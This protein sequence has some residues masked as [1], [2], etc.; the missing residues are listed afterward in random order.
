MTSNF[1]GLWRN[2]LFL[3]VLVAF[4]IISIWWL[5]IQPL[6]SGTLIEQKHLWSSSYVF[7]SF[8]GGLFGILI[9]RKWGGYRSA[10]GRSILA[11]SLGLFLQT[12]GQLVYN[13]YTLV[14][15]VEAP[16]PSLGDLGY[17][18]SIFAYLYGAILLAKTAGVKISLKSYH[19]QLIAVLFPLLMLSAS[20]AVFLNSYEFDW[21]QP[22]KVF[23]DFGYPLGQACYV[24]VAILT[25]LLC[26][27]TLGGKMRSPVL[28]ILFALVVQY[29]C[30]SCF[31]FEA[32]QGLWYAAGPGDYFYVLSYFLMSVSLIQLG[33]MY[34]HI[35]KS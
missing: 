20:Y 3:I 18:G 16:Y 12:F 29:F 5:T 32:N 28:W 35:R 26:G 14:A 17:F 19:S 31:L 15:H 13:Y 6:S 27:N 10:V 30:D 34:E 2:Y 7:L 1:Q 23:L 24:S 8:C 22:L 25:L 21:T 9:S 33:V 4:S 11:F